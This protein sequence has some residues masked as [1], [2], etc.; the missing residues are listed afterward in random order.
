MSLAA[1]VEAHSAYKQMKRDRKQAAAEAKANP[2]PLVKLNS[3]QA[4]AQVCG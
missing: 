3:I 4:L 2:K 1:K